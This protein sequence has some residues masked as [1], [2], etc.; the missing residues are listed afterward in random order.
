MQIPLSLDIVR[1][2]VFKV[3]LAVAAFLLIGTAAIALNLFVAFTDS[4]GLLPA[5]IVD[6]L[7]GLEYVIFGLDMICFSYFLIIESV[8]FLRDVTALL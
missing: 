4:R 5:K 3:V 7:A 1:D 6:G 8:R 2:F